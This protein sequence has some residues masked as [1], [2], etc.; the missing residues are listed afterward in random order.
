M[1]TGGRILHHLAAYLPDV[2]HAVLFVGFQALGTRG[3]ALVDGATQVRIHGEDIPV[4]AE[5]LYS[6]ALSAHADADELVAWAAR[7]DPAPRT[8]FVTHGEP[9]ASN[10]LAGRLRD[11]LGFEVEIP[12]M[13]QQVQLSS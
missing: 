3:R 5:I 10:A 4:R 8:T 9:D 11:E 2:K 1:A 12:E 13:G 7:V 6:D